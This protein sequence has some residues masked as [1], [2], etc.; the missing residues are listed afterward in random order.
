MKKNEHEGLRSRV[1]D[2][3]EEN[4][5]WTVEERLIE[6]EVEENE[7][8]IK[9]LKDSIEKQRLLNSNTNIRI[10]S[11]EESK[12]EYEE[13]VDKLTPANKELNEQILKLEKDK[14]ET[15]FIVG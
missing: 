8:M 1:K 5:K 11:V 12:A 4:S 3:K 9:E 10:K 13:R 2:S 14:R 6:Q 7:K 15:T